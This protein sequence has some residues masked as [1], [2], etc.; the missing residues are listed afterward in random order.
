MPIEVPTFHVLLPCIIPSRTFKASIPLMTQC[1]ILVQCMGLGIYS[2]QTLRENCVE[3][4]ARSGLCGSILRGYIM[5]TEGLY[6]GYRHCV[7]IS[8]SLV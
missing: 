4:E 3:K 1:A 5:A 2:K 6:N 7:L 8:F